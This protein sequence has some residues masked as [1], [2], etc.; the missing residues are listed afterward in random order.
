MKISLRVPRVDQKIVQMDIHALN[1]S[2][3]LHE[4]YQFEVSN[5]FAA[6]PSIL[7]DKARQDKY[8]EIFNPLVPDVHEK[9]TH[10]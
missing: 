10:I 3:D 6:L 8:D 5:T 1:S 9:F 4:L 7:S 2:T